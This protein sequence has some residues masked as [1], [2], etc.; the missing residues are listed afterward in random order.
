MVRF[1][2]F[3]FILICFNSCMKY[4]NYGVYRVGLS[5]FTITPNTNDLVYSVI[6][7]NSLYI[8]YKEKR[9][10]VS[11]SMR[12]KYF[13][14]YT[15]GRVAEFY[16]LNIN[17][18]KDSI[19][20][21]RKGYM[22]YYNFDGK[23]LIVQFYNNNANSSELSTEFLFIQHDTMFSVKRY[24]NPNAEIQSFFLKEIIPKN[25]KVT[26]PDW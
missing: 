24:Y 22:G 19:L 25:V 12:P 23:D 2:P 14:F 15:N 8:L 9:I 3:A 18:Q 7:T 5:K 26:R 6:D 16:N 4:N 11:G 20:E 21:A 10:N 17:I 13:K 1:I